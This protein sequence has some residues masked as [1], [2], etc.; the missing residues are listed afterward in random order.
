[1]SGA[2]YQVNQTRA[3][4]LDCAGLYV[5]DVGVAVENWRKRIVKPHALH[6]EVLLVRVVGGIDRSRRLTPNRFPSWD[7]SARRA[8]ICPK[9]QTGTGLFSSL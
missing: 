4:A 6:Q 8:R 5:S 7:R 1:V 9:I 2:G 3:A